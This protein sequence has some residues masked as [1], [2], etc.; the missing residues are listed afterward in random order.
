MPGGA[1]PGGA[2]PGGAG[3]VPGRGGV[4]SPS[5]SV[6]LHDGRT[7][8]GGPRTEQLATSLATTID[9]GGEGRDFGR[10]YGSHA[11][12]YTTE[13]YARIHDN[14]FLPTAEAPVSTFSTDSVPPRAST[15]DRTM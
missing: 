6:A 7:V 14:P 13:N 9:S 2:I 12:D 8:P 5:Q 1:I 11:S 10:D 3:G 15:N 4:P